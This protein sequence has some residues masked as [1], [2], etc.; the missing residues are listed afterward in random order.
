MWVCDGVGCPDPDGD[1]LLLWVWE[2][3]AEPLGV[4]PGD[5]EPDEL[6]VPVADAD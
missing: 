3:E 1:P 6:R 4:T 2:G 5:A